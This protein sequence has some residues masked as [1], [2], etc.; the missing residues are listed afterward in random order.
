MLA[1]LKV[2]LDERGR[3]CLLVILPNGATLALVNV[4]SLKNW[5]ELF[6]ILLSIAYTLWR[7]NR[8]T[9]MSC[10]GCRNGHVPRICPIPR[11]KRP[12][13]CPRKL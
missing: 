5:A 6:L 2:L 7:W 10:D 11:R 12:Y 9:F 4:I 3:D 13:W 8:D 1:G